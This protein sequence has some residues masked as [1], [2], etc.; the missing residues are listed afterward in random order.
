MSNIGFIGLGIMGK[1]MAKNLIKAGRK[2][3]VY[4]INPAPV[5]EGS[6]VQ[7]G[8]PLVMVDEPT[9][10]LA[11]RIVELVADTLRQRLSDSE[12]DL[13]EFK[14]THN[15]LSVSLEDRL[16]PGFVYVPGTARLAGP[17]DTTFGQCHR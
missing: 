8:D 1:P 7:P 11:P 16:P 4:D 10:G 9:E 2:L 12:R 17:R 5:A 6:A 14:K 3:V 15:V 13:Y